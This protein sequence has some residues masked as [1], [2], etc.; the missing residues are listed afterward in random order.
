MAY[1]INTLRKRYD[2]ARAKR[3][4]HIDT[5]KRIRYEKAKYTFAD[6]DSKGSNPYFQTLKE[7]EKRA[8]KKF[9]Q[10]DKK[11]VKLDRKIDDIQM[12]KKY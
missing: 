6:L 2:L 9:Y 10:E 4:A 1:K 11:L 7:K 12:S 8:T 3:D 5:I